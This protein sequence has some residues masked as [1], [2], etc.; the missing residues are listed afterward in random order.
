M[1]VS[2]N[3]RKAIEQA[4]LKFGE[5]LRHANAPAISYL[6][7]DDAFLC[8]PNSLML[9]GRANIEAFWDGAIKMGL[10]DGILT[11][12]QLL[13]EGETISELGKFV[14]KVQQKDQLVESKGKYVVVWKRDRLGVWKLHWDI[15]NSDT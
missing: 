5:A 11:T 2:E 15:W 1:T 14:L 6:Y 12:L 3:I 13:G 4:N 8:P 10:K 9:S 7:T